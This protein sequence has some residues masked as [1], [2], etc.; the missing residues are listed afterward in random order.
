[1][2]RETTI[3]RWIGLSTDTKPTTDVPVGSTFYE[4]DTFRLFIYN[5]ST[6]I[7]KQNCSFPLMVS[8]GL[9]T[10]H[11]SVNKFGH[12]PSGIQTTTTD[13]WARADAAPTQQIWLAPTAARIHSLVSSSTDDDAGGGGG[14]GAH[15]VRV[16][17]L[18]DWDTAETYEDVNMDGTTPVAMTVSAVMINRMKVS[19][20]GASGPNV[21]TITAT[22]ATDATVTALILPGDG[23]TEQAIYGV[24]SIQSFYLVRWGVDISKS[25]AAAAT[26]ELE[27]RVNEIPDVITTGFIRKDDISVQSTGTNSKERVYPIPIKYPGPCI[28]KIQG[29]ASA[30]DIDGKS[31]FDG[32]LINN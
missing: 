15:T 28:I 16:W 30:A 13:I 3:N 10:G 2:L 11:T 24:P 9:V 6:W 19:A 27:L 14:T 17:Y 20:Y 7:D 25:A 22:A 23:Q 32:Y 29:I 4:Y 21:G 18:P 26:V 1:M 31:G 5:G 12:A 8:R